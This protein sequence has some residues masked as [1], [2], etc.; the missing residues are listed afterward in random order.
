MLHK[1]VTTETRSNSET[2]IW[3]WRNSTL[4]KAKYQYLTRLVYTS[5]VSIGNFVCGCQKRTSTHVKA[6]VHAVKLLQ[7]KRVKLR[8]WIFTLICNKAKP[9]SPS[10]P[11]KEW[12]S[13]WSTVSKTLKVVWSWLADTRRSRP[14][15]SIGSRLFARIPSWRNLATEYLG[16]RGCDFSSAYDP[17]G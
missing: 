1:R 15:Y 8:T 17:Y 2:K 11:R 16:F 6:Y 9:T 14:T 3:H 5:E 12:P 13:T 4:L 10:P 7:L